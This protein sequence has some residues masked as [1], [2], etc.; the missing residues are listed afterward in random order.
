MPAGTP[1]PLRTLLQNLRDIVQIDPGRRGLNRHPQRN[2]FTA[3]APDLAA[4]CQS[5][6]QH[7]APRLAIVTGFFIPTADPPGHETD[8]PLGALFLLRACAALGIPARIAT[9]PPGIPALRAGLRH[10]ALPGDWL[11]ELPHPTADDWN[12]PSSHLLGF[13][14]THYVFIE[15]PGPNA[16][17]RCLTMRG[18]DITAQMGP[19]HRWMDKTTPAADHNSS[20]VTIGIGD[21]GNEIGMGKIDPAILADNIPLGVQIHCRIATDYLI[22]AGVSN[23]GSYALA[24]GL[25]LLRGRKPPP[26]LFDP[27]TERDVLEVMV[28]EGSLVDGVI[29]RPAVSVDGL[30]WEV[31]IEPLVRMREVL[32]W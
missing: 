1:P 14:P 3:T 7:P 26:G 11:W 12:R 24:A 19:V 30:P 10:C 20:P 27:S 17:G 18:L 22:V 5:L 28:R 13:S 23:W 32:A 25:F 8:G 6:A 15:R 9:D 29:G 31:Y 4:A 2:L 16:E 21:G